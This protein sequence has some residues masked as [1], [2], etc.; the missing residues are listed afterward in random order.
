MILRTGA[1]YL[2][3]VCVYPN[4]SLAVGKGS[5]VLFNK[6]AVEFDG[7]AL[8]HVDGGQ[9]VVLVVEGVADVLRVRRGGAENEQ[10]HHRGEEA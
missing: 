2:T 3:T 1:G 7:V 8:L 4:S 9:L 10:E 5:A 6:P